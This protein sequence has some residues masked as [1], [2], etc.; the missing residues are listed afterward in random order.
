MM[1]QGNK[2]WLLILALV[3]GLFSNVRDVSAFSSPLHHLQQQRSSFVAPP[4]IRLP[5]TYL[6]ST[7][8]EK[9]QE[10]EKVVEILNDETV[11]E[12]N[13]YGGEGW[14]IRLFNDPFNKREF[15]A[16]CLIAICGKS[17]TES[18]QIMM[19]AHNDGYVYTHGKMLLKERAGTQFTIN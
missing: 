7:V 6:A 18:Y 5:N 4:T 1:S 13:K 9:P 2:F 10:K 19:Q 11:E 12:E 17:D 3:A 14:E 16:R 8:I 15:V